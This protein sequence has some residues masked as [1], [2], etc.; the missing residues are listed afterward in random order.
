MCTTKCCIYIGYVPLNVVYIVDM[1][2]VAYILDMQNGNDSNICKW[3]L[4]V[5]WHNITQYFYVL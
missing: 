4:R 1:Q 3:I 5:E 2:N